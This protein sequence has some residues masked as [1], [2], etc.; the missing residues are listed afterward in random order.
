MSATPS[1]ALRNQDNSSPL[2]VADLPPALRDR[3]VGVTG[4]YLLMVYP[5][6]DIWKRRGP[7]GVH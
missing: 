2:S 6:D 1:Q 3:F 7:E 5:K 4:K